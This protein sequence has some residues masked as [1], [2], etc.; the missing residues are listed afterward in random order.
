MPSD[1][2][3]R[4]TQKTYATRYEW[5]NDPE[6]KNPATA[7]MTRAT[8]PIPSEA[9]CMRFNLAWLVS[10]GFITCSPGFHLGADPPEWE[11][12]PDASLQEVAWPPV[13][14]LAPARSSG[15]LARQPE[16]RLDLP[17]RL[18][19]RRQSPSGHPQKPVV[20]SCT[21]RRSRSSLRRR[22]DRLARSSNAQYGTREAD[23]THAARSSRSRNP[24][25]RGNE[26][27]TSQTG[28]VRAAPSR[29]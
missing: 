2:S 9:R 24:C 3:A 8:T 10:A 4:L 23:S 27:R 13:G 16:C 21:S 5:K 15:P 7:Q 19:Y 1:P 17:V 12:L 28:Y 18:E 14:E 25:S 29:V 11:A 26:R 6:S 20:R 22:S